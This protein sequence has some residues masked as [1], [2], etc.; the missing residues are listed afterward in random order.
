[1]IFRYKML[2]FVA[3]CCECCHSATNVATMLDAK[4]VIS[5][6]ELLLFY[7]LPDLCSVYP[8]EVHTC[9]Q[10]CYV[11]LYLFGVVFMSKYSLP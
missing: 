10:V 11:N 1:M 3:V 7:E 9:W 8:D 6:A 5:S 2:R 4:V